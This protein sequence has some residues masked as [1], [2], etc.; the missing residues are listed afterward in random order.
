M[1][2]IV[3]TG[4]SGFVGRQ[5]RIH[6]EARGH[7]VRGLIRQEL[8]SS[9][10]HLYSGADCVV[11]LAARA[12]VLNETERDVPAAFRR[13][14]VELTQRVFLDSLSA[15]V[16]RFVF[17]SS[18]GVLGNASPPGGFTDDSPQSPHDDYSRSKGEAERWLLAHP[19]ERAVKV[20]IRPPLIHGPGARGNFGRILSAAASGFPLPVGGLNARRSMIGLR[21]LCDVTL[22]AALDPRART[23][24]YLASDEETL[25]V[26][27]LTIALRRLFGRSARVPWVP[28]GVLAS[29]L[30]IVGKGADANR[31]TRTLELRPMRAFETF[32]WRPPYTCE[33]ELSWT[34]QQTQQGRGRSS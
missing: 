15:G 5:F 21:N 27:E 26:R 23:T 33:Q 18:A 19:D 16:R 30:R 31:L 14:N 29:L 34:V 4:A 8:E 12:H 28:A 3:V 2:I 20:I 7:E 32:G 1:A 9:G 25:S 24:T 11:H 13:A 10:Q 22:V 6:C 17:M